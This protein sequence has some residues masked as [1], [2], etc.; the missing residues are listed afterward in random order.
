MAPDPPDPEQLLQRWISFKGQSY[1]NLE[2]AHSRYGSHS[3]L[4]QHQLRFSRNCNSF[5]MLISVNGDGPMQGIEGKGI[6][7]NVIHIV[8]WGA[9]TRDS[10]PS[11]NVRAVYQQTSKPPNYPPTRE[12]LGPSHDV[13]Y[14]NK[15]LHHISYYIQRG[16]VFVSCFDTSVQGSWTKTTSASKDSSRSW[17]DRPSRR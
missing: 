4:N 15:C 16:C 7:E 8:K 3:G 11:T 2:V 6:V 5:L 14:P 13:V 9:H 10:C 17:G 1:R 12:T